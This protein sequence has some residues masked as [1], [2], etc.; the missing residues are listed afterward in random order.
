MSRP[1]RI[2]SYIERQYV[3]EQ[4]AVRENVEA[5]FAE[6]V[7]YHVGGQTLTREDIVKA[8]TAVRESPRRGRRVEPSAFEE[9]GDIVSWHIS[10]TLPTMGEDGSDLSQESDLRAVFNADNKIEEVWSVDTST[11]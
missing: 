9:D 6:N 8:V 3:S 11:S 4:G 10:A 7:A 1:R 5:L 2:A